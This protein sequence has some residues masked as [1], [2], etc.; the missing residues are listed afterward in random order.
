MSKFKIGD[1]VRYIGE[2]PDLKSKVGT[3]VN[4]INY[5]TD[6]DLGVVFDEYIPS[7]HSLGGLCS[8]GHGLWCSHVNLELISEHRF[9]VIVTSVGDTTTAKLLHGK[10]VE[11][12]VS[13]KRYYKD[14][15]SEEAAVEAVCKKLFG[16]D[17]PKEDTEPSGINCKAVS[18]YN[19]MIDGFTFTR[20]KIYEFSDGR[21]I[22]D[23]EG[24]YP[25]PISPKI[26]RFDDPNF[27]NMFVKLVDE[28]EQYGRYSF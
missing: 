8:D 12:E 20:G 2:L 15:Y 4:V 6:S 24:W 9:N 23:F 17:K 1:R 13:V 21:C 26:T 5:N 11:K 10:K 28:D 25:A 16:E 18:L 19:C 14:D 7:G 3:V 22:S 27:N